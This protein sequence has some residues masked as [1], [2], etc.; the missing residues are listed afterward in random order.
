M[1]LNKYI[2]IILSFIM[3]LFGS[4]IITSCENTNNFSIASDALIKYKLSDKKLTLYT[5]EIS[6]GKSNKIDLKNEFIDENS[7]INQY[8]TS[9]L[10]NSP[11]DNQDD[12]LFFPYN[13]KK[14]VSLNGKGYSLIGSNNA[15][16]LLVQYQ[17]NNFQLKMFNTSNSELSDLNFSS[18]LDDKSRVLIGAFNKTKDK[19]LTAYTNNT[20]TYLLE[21]IDSKIN[22]IK[23]SDEV[24][25]GYIACINDNFLFLASNINN[26]QPFK[27]YLF[28]SINFTENIPLKPSTLNTELNLNNNILSM[29]STSNNDLLL[30]VNEDGG[31]LICLYK[32]NIDDNSIKKLMDKKIQAQDVR[33]IDNVAYVIS[34]DYFF[35]LNTDFELELLN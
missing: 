23:L 14:F 5:K 27:L 17:K 10:I 35:K 15:N 19:F 11:N 4:L 22:S 6:T 25:R 29:Y 21:V 3:V 13:D 7:V 34:N 26:T 30:L 16:L 28:D 2:K 32:L 18:P 1:R 31:N 33:I 9:W 8:D 20:G 12:Q 24:L